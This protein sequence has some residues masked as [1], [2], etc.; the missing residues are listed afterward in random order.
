MAK[1]ETIIK[2]GPEYF[3]NLSPDDQLIAIESVKAQLG[4]KPPAQP[5]PKIEEDEV[6]Q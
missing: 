6:E 2:V 4:I 5:E 3:K 1:L